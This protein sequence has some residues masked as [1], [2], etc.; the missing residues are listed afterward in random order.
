VEVNIV[1]P[2]VPGI[3]EAVAN[4]RL[5]RR[6][7]DRW[8][9][10][11]ELAYRV[12]EGNVGIL[13]DPLERPLHGEFMNLRDHIAAG[14]V[15]MSGRHLQHGDDTQPER[16]MEVFTNCSTAAAS[17]IKLY[18]LLNG[19]GVGRDY[20]DDLMLVNWELMPNIVLVLDRPT[21]DTLFLN[22]REMHPDAT[23][24]FMTRDE[25]FAAYVPAHY[26]LVSDD[27]E[28]WAKAV[29]LVERLAH[30]GRYADETLILDFS[31][32]RQE[33]SPIGGMQDRPAS[34]PLPLMRAMQA[35]ARV[36]GAGM[37][38]WRQTMEID[39]HLAACVAVGGVRR[40]ARIAVKWWRD[41]DILDFINVKRTGG[42]WSANNSVAVDSEFWKL[43]ARAQRRRED[44]NEMLLSGDA[45]RALRVF[46]AIVSAQYF[47]ASGEPGFLNVDRINRD[48]TGFEVYA[49]GEFLGGDKYEPFSA[50]GALSIFES[51]LLQQLAAVTRGRKYPFI[52]NPCGEI[53]LLV[54]G[55]YCVIADT[56]PYHC[57]SLEE[58][59]DAMLAATRALIRVNLMS[60]L[61]DTEVARTNRIGVGMTGIFEFAWKFFGLGFH[62][63][64][65][66][67]GAGEPFW[68]FLDTCRVVIEE[69]AA[70]YSEAMGM[71]TPHTALTIKPAG[72]TSKLYG[73]TEGAHLPAM[74]EYLRFI[75][76]MN[77]EQA[78]EYE[79]KGYPVRYNVTDQS[80]NKVADAI[81]GFP[82]RPLIFDV[83]PREKIVLASEATM[84]EQY[85]WVALLERYWLGGERGG[86]VSYT[87]KYDKA[88][89]DFEQ[90][91]RNVL[92]F[93]PTV[94]AIAVMPSSDW[95]ETKAKYG[96]VPEEPISHE[97]YEALV[98]VIEE[99]VEL[100]S[101]E[102]LYCDGGACPL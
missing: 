92:A 52:C 62:D 89:V 54:L 57:D 98:Q 66:E 6:R 60:S 80:G 22:S 42:L 37:A 91:V 8:E 21:K 36:K 73:V 102:H 74:A 95:R 76:L 16:N 50:G 72:T 35:A 81:V 17:F 86:Q 11:P 88:E 20:S 101:D 97:E 28:G 100:I 43:V 30:D 94:R 71:P 69:E 55:G 9:T 24:E 68:D 84:E 3:G 47:H 96:Y 41:A 45:L 29:E 67:K 63:L 23:G 78:A 7:E 59:L 99:A 48:M 40:A 25:A 44:G 12:A 33:G 79:A 56:V 83:V 5:L 53:P 1:R 26:H 93:Q 75:Q 2:P 61:Y 38:R 77:G 34:G 10:W 46:D 49:S 90:Y 82:T 85:T 87:L 4:S 58:V 64:L 18:L 19:S 27:R 13:G 14:R 51:D 31:D 32:V 65:D 39:H 70:A 15:L